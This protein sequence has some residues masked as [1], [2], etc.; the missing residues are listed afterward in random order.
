ME[1]VIGVRPLCFGPVHALLGIG[2]VSPRLIDSR[3]PSSYV[4]S[5]ALDI[6]LRN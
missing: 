1:I 3:F 4:S 2:Y 6:C 5:R